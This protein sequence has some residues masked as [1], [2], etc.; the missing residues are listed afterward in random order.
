VLAVVFRRSREKCLL[1]SLCLVRLVTYISAP[2]TGSSLVTFN[3][4]DFYENMLRKSEFVYERTEISDPL[5]EDII[6]FRIFGN[7]IC[8]TTIK[9][10]HCYSSKETLLIFTLLSVTTFFE[11]FLIQ[12]RIQRDATIMYIGLLVKYVLFLSDFYKIWIFTK[13]SNIKFHEYPSSGSRV[14]PCERTDR[15]DEANSSSSQFCED[16]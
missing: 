15:H 3:N 13:Y 11:T 1:A 10:T 8:S 2:A 14:V 5:H 9:R 7:D 16:A 6:V 12:R 4:G